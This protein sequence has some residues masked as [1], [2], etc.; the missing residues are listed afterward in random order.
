MDAML[1]L[2]RRPSPSTYSQTPSCEPLDTLFDVPL[3]EQLC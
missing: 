3:A 2:N 1:Q